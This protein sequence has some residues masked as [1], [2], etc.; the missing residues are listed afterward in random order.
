MF[1]IL[2]SG[3]QSISLAT[4]GTQWTLSASPATAK[5]S[6]VRSGELVRDNRDAQAAKWPRRKIAAQRV[7]GP[8]TSEA[9]GTNETSCANETS[10][11]DEVKRPPVLMKPPALTHHSRQLGHH[12]RRAI[13]QERPGMATFV[14][15]CILSSTIP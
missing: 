7:Q 2:V 1:F 10:G 6:I 5:G 3:E 4:G 8:G 9:S 13:L 14:N 15:V 12:R 11:A